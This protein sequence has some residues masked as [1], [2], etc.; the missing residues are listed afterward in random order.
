MGIINF[1]LPPKINFSNKSVRDIVLLQ[2]FVYKSSLRIVEKIKGKKLRPSFN[3]LI[4]MR[5]LS[6]QKEFVDK[7]ASG[8]RKKSLLCKSALTFSYD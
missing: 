2:K 6:S 7:Y 8:K 3:F 4:I 5:V 1:G